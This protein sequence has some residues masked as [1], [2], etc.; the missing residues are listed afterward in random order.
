MKLRTATNSP[1][2]QITP[3]ARRNEKSLFWRLFPAM[4]FFGTIAL[5]VLLIYWYY[6][7]PRAVGQIYTEKHEIGSN[8]NAMIYSILVKQGDLVQKGS[9]VVQ[10]ETEQLYAE[11]KKNEME[12]L[13]AK[14]NVPANQ[15]KLQLQQDD[16]RL[17]LEDSQILRS[18]EIFSSQSALDQ[19]QSVIGSTRADLAGA[20]IDVERYTKL[21]PS[22]A[23]AKFLLDNA[24]TRYNM[25]IEIIK[26]YEN[27]IASNLQ[28]QKQA[29]IRYAEYLKRQETINVPIEQ[30]MPPIRT[31]VNVAET[32]IDVTKALLDY[33]FLKSPVNGIVSDIFK[34]EG[35]GLQAGEI[36]LSIDKTD[37]NVV[38][39]YIREEWAGSLVF[40][41]KIKLAPRLKKYDSIVGT[42]K[43]ISPI[44]TVIPPIFMEAYNQ[45][46]KEKGI[47]FTVLLDK[48]WTGPAGATFDIAL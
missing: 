20:A 34:F 12:L 9:V 2:P 8:R 19:A 5:I 24:N 4:I 31:E 10:L 25:D 39:A 30:I 37:L 42:I 26:N 32:Q 22:G 21:V 3:F 15:A 1:T 46:L 6:F 16:L 13:V 48:P 18:I 47:R 36:I 45:Q 11:L 44:V 35:S 28:R 17:R 7:L 43:Y 27:V 14:Q 41:K 33:S 29:E 23:A 38:E 40:N